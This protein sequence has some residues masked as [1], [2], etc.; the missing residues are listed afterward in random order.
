MAKTSFMPWIIVVIIIGLIL[1][2]ILTQQRKTPATDPN[3][4]KI[5]YRQALMP[6][7]GV[8]AKQYDQNDIDARIAY[9]IG[10]MRIIIN[11]QSQAIMKLAKDVNSLNQKVFRNE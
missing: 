5:D 7:D 1:S 11:N 9:N 6:M 3:V 4:V 10:V 2:L 8:W